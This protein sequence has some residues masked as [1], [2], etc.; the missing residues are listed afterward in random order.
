MLFVRICVVALL[1]CDCCDLNSKAEG[2]SD[3]LDRAGFE[4]SASA[5]SGKAMHTGKS[6]LD[7]LTL[8]ASIDTIAVNSGES[9]LV[10]FRRPFRNTVP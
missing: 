8:L 4:A 1:S 3:D 6:K 2:G 5:L 10:A 9:I 7:R